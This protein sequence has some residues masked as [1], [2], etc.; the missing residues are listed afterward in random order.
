M[1]GYWK[2]FFYDPLNPE[3]YKF[4]IDYV[5]WAMYAYPIFL[6][7]LPLVTAILLTTFKPE[8]ADLSRAVAV[9][10][11]QQLDGQAGVAHSPGRVDSRSQLEADV[12]TA[13]SIAVQ[14]RRF[15]KRQ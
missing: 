1:I 15:H 3:T 7:Q 12:V 2:E 14:S 9:G 11:G 8:H 13:D 4:L 5:T 6:L 10:T